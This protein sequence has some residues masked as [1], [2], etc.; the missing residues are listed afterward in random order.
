MGENGLSKFNTEYIDN[1]PVNIRKLERLCNAL[2]AEILIPTNDF[3]AQSSP[4]PSNIERVNDQ[5]IVKLANRYEVSRE[6]ILRRFLDQK[7]VSIRYYERKAKEWAAQGKHGKGGDWYAT[8]NTYLS[9]RFAKEIASRHYRK[10][11]SLEHAAGLLGIKA[12][13]FEGLE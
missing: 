10:Q 2:A 6:A 7:R 8:T 13:N 12:K 11:L 4:L 3:L 9:E 1:L 5:E